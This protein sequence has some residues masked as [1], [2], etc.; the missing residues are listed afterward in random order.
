MCFQM[1]KRWVAQPFSLC[2]YRAPQ[3]MGLS[4]LVSRGMLIPSASEH[5]QKAWG[6]GHHWDHCWH[7]PGT[8]PGSLSFL[9]FPIR[10]HISSTICVCVCTL[11]WK[12]GGSTVLLNRVKLPSPEFWTIFPTVPLSFLCLIVDYIYRLLF[13]YHTMFQ[14]YY[15]CYH[16]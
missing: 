13:I 7:L 14:E 16:V 12:W 4:T 6:G 1:A 5:P 10:S 3:R 9:Q 8:L 15:M 2:Y 11:M